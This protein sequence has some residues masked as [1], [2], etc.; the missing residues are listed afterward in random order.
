MHLS[1]K[2]F[3]HLVEKAIATLPPQF[4]VWIE[5][6][7]VIVKAAHP[8]R[9]V[10]TMRRATRWDSSSVPRLGRGRKGC[11]RGLCSIAIR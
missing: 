8:H 5:E 3:D 6:V 2:T 9:T 10:R 4:A 11:P 7:P 1:R